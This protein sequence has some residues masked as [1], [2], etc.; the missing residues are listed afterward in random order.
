MSSQIRSQD[1]R[2]DEKDLGRLKTAP[3][4][5]LF[6]TPFVPDPDGSHGGSVYLGTYLAELAKRA[7]VTLVCLT[8]PG[9]PPL[10]AS[11]AASLQAAH[12]VPHRHLRDVEGGAR[13]VHRGRT[14]ARWAGVY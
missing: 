9:D 14:L 12:P 1:S 13:W 3:V 7:E 2:L 10:P 4:R 5:V 8:S 11:L 6:V